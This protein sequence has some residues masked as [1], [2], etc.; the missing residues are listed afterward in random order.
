MEKFNCT[1]GL[2]RLPR[3]LTDAK[4]LYFGGNENVEKRKEIKR[5][6]KKNQMSCIQANTHI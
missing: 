3:V 6:E 4:Y 2:A 1:K 5:N